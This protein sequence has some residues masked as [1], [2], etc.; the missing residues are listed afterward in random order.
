MCKTR[1]GRVTGIA[2][3]EPRV[4]FVSCV[5][6]TLTSPHPLQPPDLH[7]SPAEEKAGTGTRDNLENQDWAEDASEGGAKTRR[8]GAVCS[9]GLEPGRGPARGD[10]EGVGPLQS[11]PALRENSEN[12]LVEIDGPQGSQGWVSLERQLEGMSGGEGKQG[13]GRPKQQKTHGPLAS[14]Y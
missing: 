11:V 1:V 6:A 9:R 14:S 10:S 8:G 2:T 5:P 7:G 3:R 12:C 13:K 4:Y